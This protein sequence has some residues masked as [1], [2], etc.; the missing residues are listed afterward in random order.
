MQQ[1]YNDYIEIDLFATTETA[2]ILMALLADFSFEM[3]EENDNG[4]KAYIKKV[5]YSEDIDAYLSELQDSI[6]FTFEKNTI[7][8]QNW[9]EVWESNF[10]P[11]RIGNFCGIRATFHESLQPIDYELII[12]P[13]MAFGTGHHETTHLMIEAMQ[14]LDFDNKTVLDYGC[15]TGIL[16]FLAKKLHAGRLVAVDNEYPAYE[17]TL[18]NAELNHTPL[19]KVI[20]GTLEEVEEDNFEI[21]LANINRNVI[22]A[23]LSGLYKK[24]AKH[25]AL[26]TTGFLADDEPIM[27]AEFQKNNFTVIEKTQRGYWI[28]FKLKK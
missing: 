16:S 3:F 4:V 1:D 6:D 11:L 18:E 10:H 5:N 12:N 14:H 24:L 2:E 19:E 28:C 15:G 13:K 25:G 7:V 20:F 8:S 23:S 9:N 21:I 27:L 17:S 22:T 26:V